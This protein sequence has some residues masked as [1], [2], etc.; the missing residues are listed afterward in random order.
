MP[1]SR[2]VMADDFI[3][4]AITVVWRLSKRHP[5]NMGE[6]WPDEIAEPIRLEVYRELMLRWYGINRTP[7]EEAEARRIGKQLI[8]DLQCG[9]A[10][11]AVR[12]G[13]DL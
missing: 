9:L 7:E 3:E 4:F 1:E 5:I 10:A 13:G 11:R 12:S 8:D 2:E 6:F